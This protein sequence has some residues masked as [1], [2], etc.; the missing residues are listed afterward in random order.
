MGKFRC[1]LNQRLP[2]RFQ[3]LTVLVHQ[4]SWGATR[5][6]FDKTEGMLVFYILEVEDSL[7]FT[8]TVSG[9]RIP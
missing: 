8:K 7:D 5:T 9:K 3:L 4:R 6:G 2:I 1:L